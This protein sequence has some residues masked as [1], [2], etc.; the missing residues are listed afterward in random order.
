V[1]KTFF[2]ETT[3]GM[4][5]FPGCRLCSEKCHYRFFVNL[6]LQDQGER[7]DLRR[8]TQKYIKQPALEGMQDVS[9]SLKYQCD[10]LLDV[11][12][13]SNQNLKICFFAQTSDCIG[14][15]GLALEKMVENLEP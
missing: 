5:P 11:D 13:P 9:D 2:H 10:R 14:L 3:V 6:A 7:D 8:A 12:S 4:A 1:Q 15:R